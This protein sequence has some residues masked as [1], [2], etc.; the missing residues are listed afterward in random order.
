MLL[1]QSFLLAN[2]LILRKGELF[3]EL[4]FDDEGETEAKEEVREGEVEDEDVPRRPHVLAPHHGGYNQE[5]VQ[6]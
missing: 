1:Q 6:N 4:V 5:I 2:N 3:A